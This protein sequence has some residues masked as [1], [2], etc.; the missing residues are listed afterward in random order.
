MV[1][2]LPVHTQLFIN[3]QFV[4]AKHGKTFK[5]VNP[6]T[7]EVYETVQEA[8]PEDVEIAVAAAR[9]AFKTWKDVAPSVRGKMIRKLADLIEEHRFRLAEIE[10][11]NN[12]KPVHN[13]AE[14]DLS[15]AITCYHHYAGW[16]DKISGKT[17]LGENNNM[18]YTVREPVGVVAQ[19]VTWNFPIAMQAWK[20]APALAAGC[21]VVMKLNE[22]TPLT[23]LMVAQLVVEAGFPPGVVNMLNGGPT[24]GE[25]LVRH[26]D[27]DKVAFT[28]SSEIAKKIVAMAAESNLKR[29]HLELG[30]KSPLIVCKDADIDAAIETAHFGLF[31]NQG[32]C[33]TA[34]S[35]IFVHEDIYETFKEKAVAKAKKVVV[36]DPADPK[37]EQG[38]QVDKI[39]FDRILNFIEKGKAD[40]AKLLC[41]GQALNRKGF[42]IEPTVFGEVQDHHTIAKEEIFG[43]VMQLLK[44]KTLEEVVERANNTRF[45]LAAGVCTK[46]VA[47]AMK[48]STELRV[49]TVWVNQYNNFDIRVPFGGFKQSGWGREL[50][51][52]G[53]DNYLE[54][55]TIMIPMA[56]LN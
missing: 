38:A 10:S 51:E 3:N 49:G 5:T 7:G 13:A 55:K 37:T 16:A 19:F 52:A 42:F 36:G 20:L 47:T 44:F 14:V 43:P 9:N 28:G 32:Q 39:Q 33:C 56:K 23:G 34:S 21:T 26:M 17:F 4:N 54:T 40:G 46:D 25:A 35:R 22:K 30:G 8:G 15:I 31:F 50:G 41:G 1:V 48:L 2:G 27:V 29:V 11:A 12:G 6:A 24:V 53:L 18:C 45:G